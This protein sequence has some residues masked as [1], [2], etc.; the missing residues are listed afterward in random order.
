M[1]QIGKAALPINRQVDNQ[2]RAGQVRIQPQR[3]D[4]HAVILKNLAQ[5]AAGVIVTK[6]ANKT[7]LSAQPGNAY[8]HVRRRSAGT[9][10]IAVLF[11]RHQIN[12][13][14]ADNP[15]LIHGLHLRLLM[16]VSAPGQ[17]EYLDNIHY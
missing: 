16:P 12:G 17:A 15:N 10:Q 13:G 3:R 2:H 6:T 14:I 11:F 5:E 8:P 7:A 4:I 9:F 1:H